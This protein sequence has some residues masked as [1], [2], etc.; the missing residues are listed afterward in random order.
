MKQ[1][2]HKVG[3]IVGL[4]PFNLML[5]LAEIGAPFEEIWPD[6]GNSWVESLRAKDRQKFGALG[7]D[8]RTAQQVPELKS[9]EPL[10]LGV[11]EI[12]ARV[13]EKL[14]RNDKWGNAYVSP[15]SIQKH[16]HLGSS[17]LSIA[18]KE[19][20]RIDILLSQGH[21]GPY[22]LNPARRGIIERIAK[23]RVSNR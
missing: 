13:I 16:T 9:Q 21:S 14:W 5:H 11:S 23:I 6:V 19:L 4:H 1:P 7:T 15:E 17:D 22:S 3:I 18:I 2:I 12:A 8:V 10:D 20:V